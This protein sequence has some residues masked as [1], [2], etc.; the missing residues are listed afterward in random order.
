ME[1]IVKDNYC[2]ILKWSVYYY[3]VLKLLH[4]YVV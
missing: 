2:T 1:I 4:V 3:A